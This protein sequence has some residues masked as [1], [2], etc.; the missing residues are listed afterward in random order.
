LRFPVFLEIVTAFLNK[1]NDKGK[2]I[3]IKMDR[4]FISKKISL[5]AIFM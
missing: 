1:K 2:S 3:I 4:T 5:K